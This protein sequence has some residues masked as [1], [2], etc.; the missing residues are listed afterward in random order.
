MIYW[1]VMIGVIGAIGWMGLLM[2]VVY[3]ATTKQELLVVELELQA[4][5]DKIT[6][7]YQDIKKK[8]G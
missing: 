1:I 3:H 8:C 7:V 4:L 6:S 5:R 2:G